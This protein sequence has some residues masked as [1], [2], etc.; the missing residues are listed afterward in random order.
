MSSNHS[1]FIRQN[2][3]LWLQE[4]NLVAKQG[5][6]GREMAIEFFLSLSI[7]YVKGYL[8][9]EPANLGFSGKHDNHYTT[10]HDNSYLIHLI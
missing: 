2:S 9:F 3:L 1:Q 10:E 7:S 8:G 6:T 5:E 4:R